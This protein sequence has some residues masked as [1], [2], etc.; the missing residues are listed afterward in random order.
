MAAGTASAL[1]AYPVLLWAGD[2]FLF[3][4]APGTPLSLHPVLLLGYKKVRIINIAI[5][6]IISIIKSNIYRILFP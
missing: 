5:L 1:A 6:Y 4:F 3:R 2:S